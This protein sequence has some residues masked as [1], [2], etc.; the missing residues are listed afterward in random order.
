[1]KKKISSDTAALI[2]AIARESRANRTE[3]RREDRGKT[4]R[5]YLT[6]VLLLFTLVAVSWQVI[7]M[8]R[9]YEPIRAQAKAMSEQVRVMNSQLE[10]MQNDRRPWIGVTWSIPASIKLIDAENG[11]WRLPVR[12]ALKNGG[13]TAARNID[14]EFDVDSE[15]QPTGKNG[16]CRRAV[17]VASATRFGPT[18]LPREEKL[19]D[20]SI[21][22]NPKELA[23]DAAI[24]QPMMAILVTG[25]VAY[26][27]ADRRSGWTGFRFLVGKPGPKEPGH[28]KRLDFSGRATE[29]SGLI[30][31]V[32][33]TGN[34]SE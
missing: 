1:M 6:I 31:E 28:M 2:A 19:L 9:V 14:V 10:T 23:R 25:C 17:N 4:I 15:F 13:D 27:Y 16:T 22:L 30:T 32:H 24:P 18:I 20:Y 11:A 21:T 7:E 26:I 33:P 3:E 12:L 5:E 29:L 8:V 34:L